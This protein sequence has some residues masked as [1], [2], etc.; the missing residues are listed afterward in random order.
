MAKILSV[1]IKYPEDI[2]KEEVDK[3]IQEKAMKG[4]NDYLYKELSREAIEELI[5]KL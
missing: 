2:S 5:L 4:L 1:K 3:Q